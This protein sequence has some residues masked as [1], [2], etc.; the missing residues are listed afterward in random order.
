MVFYVYSMFNVVDEITYHY[1]STSKEELVKHRRRSM[2]EFSDNGITFS[3]IM[4]IDKSV[5]GL[6]G[7]A[8]NF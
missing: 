6:V 8:D 2:R 1:I 4:I 5:L 7:D 3:R